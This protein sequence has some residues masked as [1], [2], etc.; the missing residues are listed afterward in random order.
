[1]KNN[2]EEIKNYILSNGNF[3]RCDVCS[4]ETTVLE[5]DELSDFFSDLLN[6]FKTK[7]KIKNGIEVLK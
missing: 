2:D 7:I 1:M 6:I 4:I 5:L 3:G